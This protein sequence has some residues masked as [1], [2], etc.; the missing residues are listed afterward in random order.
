MIAFHLACA[1]SGEKPEADLPIRIVRKAKAH[2]EIPAGIV[3][4]LEEGRSTPFVLKRVIAEEGE[5]AMRLRHPN[6]PA[7]VRLLPDKEGMHHL[8]MHA[9][10]L[11]AFNVA[12]FRPHLITAERVW[13]VAYDLCAALAHLH[14]QGIIHADVK[15]ENVVLDGDAFERAVLVDME[16]AGRREEILARRA[17]LGTAATNAPEVECTC[18]SHATRDIGPKIDVW[19]VGIVLLDVITH[20]TISA[21]AV[22]ALQNRHSTTSACGLPCVR[23]ALQNMPCDT[24]HGSIYCES[25]HTAL[26]LCMRRRVRDRPTIFELRRML[27]M[28]GVGAAD[29]A[30][31]LRH[32]LLH[33]H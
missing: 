8:L 19:G 1:L 17:D 27:G 14:A 13:L 6:V 22:R 10:R 21:E 25:I 9:A 15:A 31:Q 5:L 29:A 7:T 4:V 33:C 32:Y 12:R 26:D 2:H 18:A 30:Q 20:A 16:H 24:S 28:S 11:D 23:K 3:L